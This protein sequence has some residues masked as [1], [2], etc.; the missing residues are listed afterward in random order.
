MKLRKKYKDC[1][2]TKEIFKKYKKVTNKPH[3]FLLII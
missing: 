3:I 2:A 1:Y